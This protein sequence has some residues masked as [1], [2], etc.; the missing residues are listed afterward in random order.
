M[1][2]DNFTDRKQKILT[3]MLMV[4]MIILLVK[5]FFFV[6]AVVIVVVDLYK[7]K[8]TKRNQINYPCFFSVMKKYCRYKLVCF[9]K[10]H[11]EMMNFR[12]F[13]V[14]CF[15]NFLF[16]SSFEINIMIKRI[17]LL[18]TKNKKQRNLKQK[19]SQNDNI[20][21]W[22]IISILLVS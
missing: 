3:P 4:V 5:I 6:V 1:I 18:E 15:R 21:H 16:S 11:H 9:L 2:S 13:F 7:W 19:L 14:I 8:K 12:L 10:H 22:M 20:K 17:I